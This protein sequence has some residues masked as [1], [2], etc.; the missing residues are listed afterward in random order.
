MVKKRKKIVLIVQARLTSKRFPNKVL[1]KINSKNSLELIHEK[2]KK[3]KKINEIIFAIPNNKKNKDL[4]S[5]LIKKKYK[6]F[7]GN[8]KNVLKRYY[9]CAK[10]NNLTTIIR[11]TSDCPFIDQKLI[12]KMLKIFFSKKVDY[13]SNTVPL[14]KK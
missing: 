7:L 6:V 10:K 3:V 12:K 1:N 8:E 4:E 5:F 13:L 11:L 2:L 14:K 9:D